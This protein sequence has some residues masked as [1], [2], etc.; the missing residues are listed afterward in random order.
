[1]S[2]FV[3]AALQMEF[4]QFTP[5]AYICKERELGDFLLHLQFIP[6]LPPHTIP[7]TAAVRGRRFLRDRQLSVPFATR[8]ISSFAV[9]RPQF[10]VSRLPPSINSL[11]MMEEQVSL[12]FTEFF[13]SCI[14]HLQT[15]NLLEPELFFLVLA[16]PVYK[17]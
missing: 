11:P 2:A 14:H 7:V 9:M 17:M 5:S 3:H 10:Y 8:F 1:M 12:C 15:V 6:F 13:T 4:T 16:H